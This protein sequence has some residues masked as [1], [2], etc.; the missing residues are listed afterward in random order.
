MTAQLAAFLVAMA[1]TVAADPQS[2]TTRVIRY[3]Y[4]DDY[5]LSVVDP[6]LKSPRLR[7]P[8][9]ATEAALDA[10]EREASASSSL[11]IL[12]YFRDVP[13]E[14][15]SCCMLGKLAGDKGFHC[16]PGF[17]AARITMRNPNRAHNRKM[18]FTGRRRIPNWGRRIMATFQRCVNRHGV[19]FHKCCYAAVNERRERVRWDHYRRRQR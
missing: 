3:E 6:R 18:M 2:T 14:H 4:F 5:L 10:A 7:A 1:A 11:D 8:A 16:H 12:G 19:Q 15:W 13:R 17:Y 9:N